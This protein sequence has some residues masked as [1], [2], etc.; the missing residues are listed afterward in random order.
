M[1]GKTK[2]NLYKELGRIIRS[3][4]KK[5]KIKQ[6]DLANQLGL[7]RASIVNIEQGRHKPQIHV[8][9]ELCSIFSCSPSDILPNENV[10]IE[11]ISKKISAE[12]NESEEYLVKKLLVN[13]TKGD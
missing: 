4:R 12:L 9:Y 1:D 10:M 13:A 5:L 3:K 6:E 7:S 8:L 2:L 11:T